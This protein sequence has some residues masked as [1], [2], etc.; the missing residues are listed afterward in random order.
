MRAALSRDAVLTTGL[1]ILLAL[2]TVAAAL[3]QSRPE[4]GI[5]LDSASSSRD[6]SRAL[7]LWLDALGYRVSDEVG[8]AFAVPVEAGAA[9]ILEPLATDGLN[10]ADLEN[11]EGWVNDG[12]ILIYAA[13]GFTGSALPAHFGFPTGFKADPSPVV[14]PTIPLQAVPLPVNAIAFFT[15]ETWDFAPLA[16]L[17]EGPIAVEFAHG[18]G[19]VVLSTAT[20]PFSNAGLK[21]AGSAE[22]ILSAIDSLPPGETIWFDEWHHGRR[23]AAPGGPGNWMIDAPAGRAVLF[24]AAALFVWI[25]LSGRAFGRPL[26]LQQEAQRRAPEEYVTAIANLNRRAGNRRHLLGQ[27]HRGLKRSLSRRWPIDPS[28]PD[29]A[30]LEALDRCAPDMEIEILRRLLAGLSRVNV[31][32]AEMLRLAGEAAAWMES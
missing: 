6:G 16:A 28:L 1:F 14:T 22:F 3:R 19:R 18:E 23:G 27:Y 11:V 13:Q 26:L 2:L 8:P 21:Q 29:Q 15:P 12:G 5:P 25:A 7:A 4:Q 20:Y 17:P 24:S 30:F 31:N 32:E 9:I 10:Q